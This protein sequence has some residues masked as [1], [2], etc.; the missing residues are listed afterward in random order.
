MNKNIRAIFDIFFVIFFVLHNKHATRENSR[1][2]LTKDF[3][4]QGKKYKI[5]VLKNSENRADEIEFNLI[6]DF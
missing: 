1:D 4:V 6:V 3:R 5:E 2:E